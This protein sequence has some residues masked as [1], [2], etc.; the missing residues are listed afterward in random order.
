MAPDTFRVLLGPF[1]FTAGIV[2]GEIT[3]IRVVDVP[4]TE[5]TVTA[6]GLVLDP[7]VQ[8]GEA[9]IQVTA[10]PEPARLTLLVFR[11]SLL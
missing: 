2:A 8:A 10:I 9:T 5:D 4:G 7:L 3:T 1:R 6:T 11:P